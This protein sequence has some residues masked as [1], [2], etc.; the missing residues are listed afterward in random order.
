MKKIL[1]TLIIPFLFFIIFLIIW[2]WYLYKNSERIA[3]GGDW[4]YMVECP[5]GTYCRSESSNPLIGGECSAY[6]SPFF[7]KME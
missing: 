3:C 2:Q 1:F 5:T 4:S 7:E 6:L